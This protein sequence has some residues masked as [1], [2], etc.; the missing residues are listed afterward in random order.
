MPPRE[1]TSRGFGLT[2][3]C[4]CAAFGTYFCMYGFRKPF[5]AAAYAEA[6][7]WGIDVKTVLVTAQVLGY[8]LSKFIGIRVIAEMPPGR[9]I[10][11]LLG[12]IL[13][14]EVALLL[15]ALTPTPWNTVWMFANGL[16][17]GMVFGLVLGFLEGRQQTEALAAGLCVSFIIADGVVKSVGAAVLSFGVTELWMPFVAGL[18]FLLPQL[19]FILMLAQV[20]QPDQKDVQARSERKPMD[21]AARSRFFHTYATGVILIIAVYILCTILRSLRSDFAPELWRGLGVSERPAIFAWSESIVGFAILVLIGT[22][23]LISNNR[24]AFFMGLAFAMAGFVLIGLGLVLH[25]VGCLSALTYMVLLGVGLYLPYIVVHTTL[26]ER[27]L[28]MTREPG[29]IG[30]L[31]YLA[32]SFGYLGYVAVMLFR[33][34]HNPGDSFLTYFQWFAGWT[35]PVCLALLV[36][37]WWYFAV[38]PRTWGQ[39]A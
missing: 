11:W 33:S 16:T 15:L 1:T 2:A 25:H 29:N 14:A 10:V 3:W 18:I 35:V 38:H 36:P 37:C 24:L 19:M 26:F 12:L 30:Y 28:A 22:T 6:T 32:D 23:T 31:M 20:P 34:V 17:L 21:R 13:A 5:T 8:T 9:R 4:L 7:L 39:R 27:L